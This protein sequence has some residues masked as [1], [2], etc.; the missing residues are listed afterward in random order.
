[1]SYKKYIAAINDT[2]PVIKLIIVMG[3]GILFRSLAS[4]RGYNHDM[5]V[6]LL[7]QQIMGEG[8]NIYYV[9]AQMGVGERA[10]YGPVWIS[11]L[12][13]LSHIPAWGAASRFNINIFLI[14]VDCLIFFTLL[15]RY[16]LKV[17]ALFFLNPISIIITGYHAQIDNLAILFGLLGVI[18]IEQSDIQKKS[19][20]SVIG[21][22]LIGSSLSTK[23]ILIFLP[24]WLAFKEPNLYKKALFLLFPYGVFILSMVPFIE[25]QNL[26]I[27]KNIFIYR[28]YGNA[29]LWKM[30]TPYN[31]YEWIGPVVFF[32]S[33]ILTLG[34]IWRKK[35]V[36]ESF[37]LYLVAIVLFS[38]SVANQYLS[39]VTPGIAANWNWGYALYSIFGGLFLSAHG[40]GLANGTGLYFPS[41]GWH[42]DSLSSYTPIIMLLALGLIIQTNNLQ[43]FLKML[44]YIQN[45]LILVWKELVNQVSKSNN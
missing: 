32:V 33:S 30:L 2:H 25:N 17:A 8:K 23:H 27:I 3:L 36:V 16:N 37:N 14:F 40:H 15:G 45:R 1:M 31:L 11:I 44:R 12:N 5:S 43:T 34:L 7:W 26:I 10:N 19:Y 29:P 20:L 39:I 9:T 13:L 24:I 4:L 28:G 42:I 18:A 38:S 22:L 21:L 6:W 41:I 35:G